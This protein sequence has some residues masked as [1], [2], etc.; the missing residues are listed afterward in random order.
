M[1]NP[2]YLSQLS[3]VE[4]LSPKPEETVKFYKEVIGLEESGR[5]G[6]SVYLRAWGEFHHHSLKITEGKEAGLGHIGWR[7][8]SAEALKDAALFIEGTGQGKG[9]TEGDLGHGAAYQFYS[10]DGHLEEV[11]WDVD[12]YDAPE[13]L[14]S[15]WKNRPQKNPGR[16]ISPRR[17]DHVTVHSRNTKACR[18]FYQKLGFNYHEGIFTDNYDIE[19]GA[20]LSV[21]NLSHDI[22]IIGNPKGKPGAVN[23]V[24]YAV[25]SREEVLLAADHII[26][27]GYELAMGG[28]TR[29]ALAEGFFFYVDEP[30]GNRFEIYAGAHLVFAPDFGPFKWK[31]SENPNDAWGRENPFGTKGEILK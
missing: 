8:D 18:E 28:P 26:E 15:K 20:W 16:G 7:A 22:A 23:H 24:C 6:Q 17:L 21:S 5:Q 1:K 12:L 3:H 14:R 31:L 19:V 27:S 4:L 10:P 29:H 9:W 2:H 30:G 11:F 25:E 13:N